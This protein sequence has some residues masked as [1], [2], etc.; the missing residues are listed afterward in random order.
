MALTK[1]QLL[2]MARQQEIPARSKMG[3]DELAA[4]VGVNQT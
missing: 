2:P 3:H 1:T 4:T